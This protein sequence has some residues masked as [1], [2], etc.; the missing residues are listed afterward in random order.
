M[1]PIFINRNIKKL[2]FV[3]VIANFYFFLLC[4]TAAAADCTETFSWLPNTESNIAG[5]TIYYGKT[6]GGPYPNAV[7][8]GKPGPVGGLIKATITVLTCGQQYYF[9]CVAVNDVGIESA[10]SNSVV[11]SIIIESD[12]SFKIPDAIYPS[13]AGDTNLWANLKFFGDQNGKPVWELYDYGFKTSS[14]NPVTL[15]PDLSFKLSNAIYQ[16]IAGNIN[17]EA[18]FKFLGY[19]NGKSLW[20]LDSYTIK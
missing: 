17:I 6:E 13:I 19:Q 9:V 14:N 11:N 8:V 7:N 18:D 10:Y 12:L 16:S 15:E 20:E 5:Y 4:E 1:V 2:W 3:L